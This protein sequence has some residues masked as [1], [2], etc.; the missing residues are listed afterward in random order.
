VIQYAR[1]EISERNDG[2]LKALKRLLGYLGP[3]WKP[4]IATC[5]LLLV[6]TGL[7]LLPPLFQRQ[8]VD[9]VI[10]TRDLSQLGWLVIGLI[11]V[12]ILLTLAEFGD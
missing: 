1:L 8:I 3:Y 7:S 11:G 5:T 2:I 12:Y 10:G 9:Q 6:S 4:L